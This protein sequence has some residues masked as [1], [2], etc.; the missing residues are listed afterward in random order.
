MRKCTHAVECVCVCVCTM[1]CMHMCA[2]LHVCVHA[3]VHARMCICMHVCERM[4]MH[5]RTNKYLL[6]CQPPEPGSV[7]A[8]I[9]A[10]DICS[11]NEPLRFSHP[12]RSCPRR[13]HPSFPPALAALPAGGDPSVSSCCCCCCCCCCCRCCSC[14]RCCCCFCCWIWEHADHA[15]Y[16]IACS[17]LSRDATCC[18]ACPPA[19]ACGV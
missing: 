1:M 6:F 10:A 13:M 7:S 8:I 3:C 17:R 9:T 12:Q 19:A 16:A 5:V 14:W 4:C 2:R 18:C 15:V 11:T